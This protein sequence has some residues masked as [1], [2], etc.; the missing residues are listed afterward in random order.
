[1]IDVSQESPKPIAPGP[2]DGFL[3]VR[4]LLAYDGSTFRGFAENV[5][6][7]TVGG[8]LREA[9][10]TILG[11][12]VAIVVAGRTDAGVHAWGQVISF[13]AR[14]ERLHP[15]AMRNGLNSMLAPSIAIRRVE[16]AEP[17]FHA[18]FSATTRTYRYRIL[19]SHTPD[20]FLAGQVWLV[21]DDL[22]VATLS[23]ASELF[24]GTHDF[25][26]FCRRAK[27]RPDATMVR[28]V[29][30]VGWELE[31]HPEGR[32]LT[33][34]ISASA[35]C[36]QMVRSVVGAVVEAGLGKCTVEDLTEALLHTERALDGKLGSPSGLTLWEVG[37]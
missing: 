35:F 3:R 7:R 22:D 8:V 37:Y 17:S 1:M 21:R 12:R 34:G 27:D 28:R 10:E 6:V 9:L 15:E 20:P 26:A 23:A 16:I 30:C 2:P 18:R 32:L 24:V 25:T 29:D 14:A 4:M 36:H 31:D 13:D 11:H 33:F 19:N 5:G